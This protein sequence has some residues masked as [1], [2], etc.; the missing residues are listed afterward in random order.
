VQILNEASH[1]SLKEVKPGFWGS[2]EAVEDHRDLFDVKLTG[3]I[4]CDDADCDKQKKYFQLTEKEDISQ[5]F[6][7]PFV[8]DI[9]GNSVSGRYY[10]LL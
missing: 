3:V 1:K 5:P 8:F 9:D 6:R 7:S 2:Y 10:T 4:S